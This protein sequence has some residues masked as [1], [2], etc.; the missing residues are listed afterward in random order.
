MGMLSETI[1]FARSLNLENK[2]SPR[3]NAD[4]IWFYIFFPCLLAYFVLLTNFINSKP[5]T[6]VIESLHESFDKLINPKGH[7]EIITTGLHW[8][9]GPLWVEDEAASTSFLMFSDTKSNQIFKWE[10]GKG[11]F[12]VGKTIYV[13]NSGCKTNSS[14]CDLMSESGSNGLLK[15]DSISLDL[16]AC[17]HGERAISLI[18]DNGL[19]IPLATH[20][21]VFRLNSPNDLVFS[22]EGHLYFTDPA[23][24]LIDKNGVLLDKQ[25]PYNGVYML[26]AEH[27]LEA[28]ET[29]QASPHVV[30]LDSTMT[31]PNGL[32]FSPDY[33]K[34]YVSD[35][36]SSHPHWK[37]FDV[38]D[39]G[40]LRT[41][42]KVFFDATALYAEECERERRRRPLEEKEEENSGLISVNP[43]IN[44]RCSD[45]VG[46]P[47][48]L[49]V[50]INGNVFASGPGGVLVL[51][52]RGELL[53]R[54][55]MD[56]PVSNV[57][58]GGDGRLYLTGGETVARVWV[59]TKPTRI[60]S[61]K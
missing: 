37:V 50:D 7:I 45:R 55:R 46:V 51:S 42:G 20:Y 10:D 38:A 16:I 34:L 40:S 44:P 30:L 60:I 57:A 36:D 3:K 59:K 14:Y 47:D 49:K 32:A 61:R 52:A 41:P 15:R 56:R 9:E 28:I 48:G 21:G 18:A 31:W 25:L 22:P 17:Q 6:G 43:V 29:R 53:G 8:T 58:F 33:S 35:S 24:G 4:I 1:E 12:T 2:I 13:E 23:F 26:R 27:I 5:S 39:D 11:L 54:L 19:R